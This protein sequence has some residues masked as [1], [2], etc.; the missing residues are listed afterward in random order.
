MTV[1]ELKEVLEDADDNAEVQ[2]VSDRL[3]EIAE[4]DHVEIDQV[5]IPGTLYIVS[6]PIY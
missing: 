1:A 2:I 5:G 3:D 6:E 4:I